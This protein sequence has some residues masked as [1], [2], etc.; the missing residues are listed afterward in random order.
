MPRRCFLAES[1]VSEYGLWIRVEGPLGLSILWR[2][3]A[4]HVQPLPP[5]GEKCIIFFIIRVLNYDALAHI[6]KALIV[7]DH[8]DAALDIANS[9]L[10]AGN[11]GHAAHEGHIVG[12]GELALASVSIHRCEAVSLATTVD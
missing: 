12:D 6:W 3:Y 10:D 4:F 5:N 11:T 7:T 9:H 8:R 2:R 1:A